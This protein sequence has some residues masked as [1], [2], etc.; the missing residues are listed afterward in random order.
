MFP[1]RAN[2]FAAQAA[3]G[4]KALLD[5]HRA[6]GEYPAPGCVLSIISVSRWSHGLYRA[7]FWASSACGFHKALSARCCA[8]K[9]W[10]RANDPDSGAS[11]RSGAGHPS[12]GAQN[13]LDSR[14]SSTASRAP[15][16]LPRQEF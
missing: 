10:Y 15:T 16:R 12:S 5:V 4:A 3:T 2:G 14:R 8:I 9:G 13:A 11:E 6:M 7:E 1:F